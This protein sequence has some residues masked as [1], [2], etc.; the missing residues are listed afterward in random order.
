MSE[1]WNDE[2]SVGYYDKIVNEGFQNK[3]GVRSYWH[4]STLNKVLEFID[5]NSSHLDYACGPGTLIGLSSSNNSMGLDISSKQ[6]GYANEN[7]SNYGKF[8]T[9]DEIDLNNFSNKFDVVTILGLIEFLKDEEIRDL[10]NLLDKV[11]KKNGKIILTTPNFR[12][13]MLIFETVQNYFGF[14]D[15]SKQHVNRFNKVKIISTFRSF[16]N[17]D[18][19]YKTFLNISI[20]FSMISHSIASRVEKIIA[21]TFKDKLGS[22]FI[23]VLT[24]RS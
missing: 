12:G 2:L 6:I 5:T 23:V 15:Y 4:I 24:K 14:I 1:F 9:L 18:F 22:I 19:D 3:K 13:K 16:S 20:V 21:T 17:Y 11:L 10:I 7:Y 8:Y